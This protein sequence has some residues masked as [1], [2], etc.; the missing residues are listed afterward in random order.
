MIIVRPNMVTI[1]LQNKSLKKEKH[2]TSLGAMTGTRSL[3]ILQTKS[4]E[5]AQWQQS[6]PA[7]TCQ[8]LMPRS[9]SQISHPSQTK[10]Y[11]ERE[12]QMRCNVPN[13]KNRTPNIHAHLLSLIS[14][15]KAKFKM[16]TQS[17]NTNPNISTNNQ[18]NQIMI[19]TNKIC[20]S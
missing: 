5:K 7:L 13:Q 12:M 18:Q 16:I 10:S 4:L 9:R 19:Q 14:I 1:I 3:Q 20:C 2:H 15:S 8:L 6:K 17:V 11:L